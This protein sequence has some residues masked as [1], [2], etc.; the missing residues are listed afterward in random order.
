MKG[1]SHA[2]GFRKGSG[3]TVGR[4]V[5]GSVSQDAGPVVRGLVAR[6]ER[7]RV[8]ASS[9]IRS[10]APLP[11]RVAAHGSVT[12]FTSITTSDSQ[13]ASRSNGLFVHVVHGREP[14][15]HKAPLG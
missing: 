5:P 12:W 8:P 6:E 2:C 9:V 11:P 4:L 1:G 10:F 14:P 3:G 13:R 7:T 15:A